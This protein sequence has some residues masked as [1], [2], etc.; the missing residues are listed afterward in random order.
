MGGYFMGGN[1]FLIGLLAAISWFF[2]PCI[3]ILL[4][5]RKLR[6]PLEKK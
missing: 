3:D 2:I 4:R 5:I 1:S 6:L